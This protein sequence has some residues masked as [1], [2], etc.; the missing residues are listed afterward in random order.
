MPDPRQ[1]VAGLRVA[2]ARRGEQQ[3]K[4]AGE[5]QAPAAEER[6]AQLHRGSLRGVGGQS[7]G[8][9][10]PPPPSPAPGRAGGLG[11]P[12][13]GGKGPGRARPWERRGRRKEPGA[14]GAAADPVAGRALRSALW[15]ALA[16]PGEGGIGLLW[17]RWATGGAGRG[18]DP[19][20][21]GGPV[22]RKSQLAASG[23]GGIAALRGRGLFKR[24]TRV[25]R[26]GRRG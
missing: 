3:Q 8:R 5:R 17:R 21:E 18:G 22:G 12:R 4:A 10:A 26:E 13:R 1:D 11:A 19:P 2:P 6:P 16:F 9:P 20:K 23:Q 14:A 25:M 15:L 24:V 7:L